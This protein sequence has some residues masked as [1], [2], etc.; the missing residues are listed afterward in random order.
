MKDTMS[1]RFNKKFTN[2]EP[3]QSERSHKLKCNWFVNN[4]IPA[5]E[6]LAFIEEEIKSAQR[7]LIE[8]ILEELCKKAR[9]TDYADRTEYD[10]A[11]DFIKNYAHSKGLSGKEGEE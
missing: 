6:I 9:E 4:D 10:V 1:Q 3:D 11:H 8:E 5:R 2:K 7:E